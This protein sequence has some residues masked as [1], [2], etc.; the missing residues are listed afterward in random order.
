MNIT[1]QL[2]EET[3]L[4]APQVANTLALLEEGA[5]VPFIAR[6][7]KERTGSLDEGRI[8]ELQKR[9]GYYRELDD[10]RNV[11]LETIKEQGK[12]TD[13]L[14]AKIESVLDRT[15]L[16]DIYLP[17]RPKRKTRAVKAREAGLE[18]LARWLLDCRQ[19]DA[20][21]LEQARS[22]L[23]PDR[24][25]DTA[26]KALRGA[27]DIVAEMV[28]DDAEV[29]KRLRT[30]ALQRGVIKSTVRKEFAE[31]KT[32]FEMY[33]DYTEKVTSLPSHRI[34]GMFRGEREKV[35]RV[36]LEMDFD[37]VRGILERKVI[38]FPHSGA[39]PVLG[40]AVADSFERLLHPATE[41]EVRKGLRERAEEEAFAVFGENLEA[42]L[43]APPAGHKRVIGIDPGFRT[44][45]KIVAVD[46]NGALLAN[47]TIFPN[48]PRN[49]VEES[50]QRLTEWV[51]RFS[52]ELIAVGNGTA[53]RETERFAR[54]A[55]AGVEE[56][57]RPIVVIVSESGASVY[58]AS[59][60]ARR[61]FPDHDLTVR[62]AVSIARRLQDPL[63]ELVK[64]D[65]KAIGVGQYQHDV[66]QSK[67]K[68]AL[69]AVVES[70]VNRVGVNVNLASKELLSHV[71]G[72]SSTTASMIVSHRTA[73]GAF[74]SREELRMVK[75]IG[76]KTFEQCA[77]FLRIP[78]APNPLDNSAVHPERYALV[79]RIAR[80]V[81]REI[82]TLIGN[83]RVL[84]SI[85]L[86]RFVDDDAGLPTLRDIIDELRKPGRDPRA[87]FSYARFDDRIREI[88]DLKP[89]MTLEG[90]VTNV[91]NFGAFVDIGVHQDGLVHI[92]E[93]ADRFVKDPRAEVRVGQAVK[94]RVMSVEEQRK[95]I[96]LSMKQV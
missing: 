45:C 73:K 71:S 91:T 6:Y 65:P 40:E 66:S 38:A 58:S 89:G 14:K 42:L 96:G 32:K 61:E 46:E 50:A 63:S 7:R 18:P 10:R 78:D 1:Q 3:G 8:R 67:L 77:P 62:G 68:Q 52:A 85:D 70:C 41:T 90:V 17:Y 28:A 37:E 88:S 36:S 54:D 48:E 59:E 27:A 34:L 56:E 69:E 5:T 24:G 75:G 13:E 94:V 87:A 86:R 4:K 84:D 19:R 39:A 26:E 60:V 51:R 57:V 20:V 53:S 11:I 44:G 12:L 80:E 9:N 23:A 79:E 93:L 92:S 29:R 16:E 25:Y 95:R 76:D 35:L 22:Y 49:N 83:G 82:G 15:E 31:K 64:I 2:I 72:L 74:R 47:T 81:S 21:P 43:M 33:Y 30:V 55:V